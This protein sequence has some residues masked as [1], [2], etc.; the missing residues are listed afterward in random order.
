MRFKIELTFRALTLSQWKIWKL[1]CLCFFEHR[2]FQLQ[3]FLVVTWCVNNKIR[4]VKRFLILPVLPSNLAISDILTDKR[5]IGCLVSVEGKSR[6][7]A[8]S[9]GR[10]TGCEAPWSWAPVFRGHSPIH[11]HRLYI[12][13]GQRYSSWVLNVVT[14]STVL[15]GHQ[16]VYCLKVSESLRLL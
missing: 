9:R 16:V 2:T 6:S 1:W 5:L 10:Q 11:V 8:R 3:S 7:S 13:P 15:I 14:F 12:S 4:S